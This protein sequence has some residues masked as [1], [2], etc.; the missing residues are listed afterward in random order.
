MRQEQRL[1]RQ[2]KYKLRATHT[3]ERKEGNL[4][5]TGPVRETGSQRDWCCIASFCRS[6]N[7]G[8][9]CS[10][11]VPFYMDVNLEGTSCFSLSPERCMGPAPIWGPFVMGGVLSPHF[12][13]WVCFFFPCFQLYD[14]N[15]NL[16]FLEGGGWEQQVM[17]CRNIYLCVCLFYIYN[18]HTHTHI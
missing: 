17:N 10:R 11:K 15:N 14:I 5:S 12:S 1:G 3:R 18:V 2:M 4:Y 6:Q 16:H 8:A 9:G 7:T 13:F